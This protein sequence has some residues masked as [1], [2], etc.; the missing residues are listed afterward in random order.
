MRQTRPTKI[1]PIIVN[2]IVSKNSLNLQCHSL[3]GR[4][5]KIKTKLIRAHEVS[6]VNIPH[7]LNFITACPRLYTIKE[8]IRTVKKAKSPLK[9]PIPIFIAL[10]VVKSVGG[11]FTLTTLSG[12]APATSSYRQKDKSERQ[13][14][15]TT[16]RARK[17]SPRNDCKNKRTKMPAMFEELSFISL[18]RNSICP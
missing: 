2:G 8:R 12:I 15:D 4:N 3:V 9:M 1:A 7:W 13:S 11:G 14:L 17:G 10:D 18:N 16:D 5:V 6:Q